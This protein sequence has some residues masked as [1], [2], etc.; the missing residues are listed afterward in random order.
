MAQM[1]QLTQN[2]QHGPGPIPVGDECWEPLLLGC[3]LQLQI[4]G[5]SLPRLQGPEM[6]SLFLDPRRNVRA[7]WTW[8]CH[9]P[10]GRNG[11]GWTCCT[12]RS[13]YPAPC[14]P[15]RK[16]IALVHLWEGGCVV[17]SCHGKARA[18]EDRGPYG[19]KPVAKRKPIPSAS[20]PAGSL[21]LFERQ[22]SPSWFRGKRHLAGR[23]PH[24]QQVF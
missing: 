22:A 6:A 12:L 13:P 2:P 5:D 20:F 14:L 15:F 21:K 17:V 3:I 16:N 18:S 11:S 1:I 4:T 24:F 10:E 9:L 19:D 8:S 7:V 23:A